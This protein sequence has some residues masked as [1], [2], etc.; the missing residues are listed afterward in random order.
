MFVIMININLDVIVC[1]VAKENAG[2]QREKSLPSREEGSGHGSL[3]TAKHPR[4][5]N[6]RNRQLFYFYV[7]C[8][9]WR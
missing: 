9:A 5:L 1:E 6:R 3:Q 4:D 2:A 7:T 8:G